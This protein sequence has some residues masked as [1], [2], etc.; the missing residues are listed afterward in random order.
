MRV[1]SIAVAIVMAILAALAADKFFGSDD[2]LVDQPAVVSQEVAT[3][4]IIVAKQNIPVG[5][6][7]KPEMLFRQKWPQKLKLDGFVT[8]D[9]S[10]DIIGLVTRANFQAREPILK[11]K[12]ANPDDPSFLAAALPEGMRAVTIKVDEVAS[13]GGFVFPGDRVD[14]LI[15]HQIE[16][17]VDRRTVAGSGIGIDKEQVAEM[18]VSNVKVLA[19]GQKSDYSTSEGVKIPKSITVEVNRKGA[20]KILLGQKQGSKISL[21]LRSLE[22]NKE[23]NKNKKESIP[24][25]TTTQ[26]ITRVRLDET[27]N[28]VGEKSVKVIRGTRVHSNMASDFR[29]EFG[30]A[31]ASS[32]GPG[33]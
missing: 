18:L 2:K 25:P 32:R 21:A 30:P 6:A 28:Y 15:R 4:D 5:T 26:G 9:Q 11:T 19:I 10:K 12:L 13:V 24:G 14:L 27:G 17:K 29:D 23:E 1:V 31:A 16:K 7:I 33:R 3:V 8:S 20:Q 22:E